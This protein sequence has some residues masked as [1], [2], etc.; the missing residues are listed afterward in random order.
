MAKISPQKRYANAVRVIM[1]RADVSWR[2]A[3]SIYRAQREKLGEPISPTKWRGYSKSWFARLAKRGITRA[4]ITLFAGL[5][6]A[7]DLR[8]LRE[9]DDARD[10]FVQLLRRHRRKCIDLG[11][12]W[13]V[14][15]A[16]GPISEHTRKRRCVSAET[17]WTTINDMARN[18]LERD[19][20]V[21]IL[22]TKIVAT[23]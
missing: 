11:G 14:Q 1:K 9:G 20:D 18:V 4:E 17:F 21:T 15:K 5:E 3:Q 22:V 19:S 13:E 12:T 2:V 7:F 10:T 6:F 8:N 16:A 23:L